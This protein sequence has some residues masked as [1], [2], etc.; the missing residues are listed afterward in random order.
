MG[1]SSILTLRC[2]RTRRLE[3]A[4]GEG[5]V[6]PQQPRQ[7]DACERFVLMDHVLGLFERLAGVNYSMARCPRVLQARIKVGLRT[8][9]A[10]R[11][12]VRFRVMYRFSFRAGPFRIL[13]GSVQGKI[14]GLLDQGRKLVC[15]DRGIT[16][17]FCPRMKVGLRIV[18]ACHATAI[19]FRNVQ[20][21]VRLGVRLPVVRIGALQQ[22]TA[23]RSFRSICLHLAGRRR[24]LVFL[25]LH[26]A[27]PRPFRNRFHSRATTGMER[28]RFE[29]LGTSQRAT[30][31]KVSFSLH[32]PVLYVSFFCG[33][34]L[35]ARAIVLGVRFQCVR[36]SK[37]TILPFTRVRANRAPLEERRARRSVR[38][39]L[40]ALIVSHLFKDPFHF[41]FA[42]QST[43]RRRVVVDLLILFGGVRHRSIRH[44]VR[45]LRVSFR[46]L[47]RT[48]V[49]HN[50]PGY[51][52]YVPLLKGG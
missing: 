40:R 22:R 34:G 27:W 4:I 52:W 46:R 13:R 21:R 38:R 30:L 31:A 44:R 16:K 41:F 28:D 24:F 12:N 10:D 39:N 11:V 18:R 6:V 3:R 33:D 8:I 49:G 25:L 36:T 50:Q 48:W 1:R 15:K 19:R 45:R 26:R 51:R 2:N 20:F 23:V 35:T 32:F 17:Q 47:P 14:R 29:Y 5:R 7:G 9:E 43:S 42:V 37:V